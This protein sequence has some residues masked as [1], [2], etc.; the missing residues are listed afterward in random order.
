MWFLPDTWKYLVT[1]FSVQLF[2]H[3]G[4]VISTSVAR[5]VVLE[6][7][8]ATSVVV[9]SNVHE[10]LEALPPTSVIVN[11]FAALSAARV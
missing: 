9:M 1:A 10:P 3:T 7:R 2:F 8:P 6:T 5:L 4:G 11:V